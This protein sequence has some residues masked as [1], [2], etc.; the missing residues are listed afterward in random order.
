MAAGALVVACASI[1]YAQEREPSEPAYGATA[2]APRP[3]PSGSALD[4]TASATVIRV[5]ERARALESTDELLHEVPGAQVRR[6]GPI[7]SF[8]GLSLRGANLEH[9]TVL[10]GEIPLGGAEGA[11][12]D[13]S[14]LPLS[15]IDRIEV[16]RGG[17]PLAL[18]FGGIGGVLRLVPRDER[19]TRAEGSVGVG[20][21]G[22]ATARAS[23]TVSGDA[24]TVQTVA[25]M[26][27]ANND[28]PY[29]HDAN[30]HFDPSDDYEARRRNASIDEGW[31]FGRIRA[32]ARGGVLDGIV[33]AY[34]RTG[35]L[36]GSPRNEPIHTRRNLARMLAA[37]RYTREANLE[38]GRHTTFRLST[39]TQYERQRF[40]DLYR[41]VAFTPTA[42]DDRILRT[43]AQA[44]GEIALARFVDLAAIGTLA[45]DRFS[46]DDDLATIDA[47]GSRRRLLGLGGELRAHGALGSIRGEIRASGRVEL[48][49]SKL[50]E[51]RQERLGDT[52]HARTVAPTF[53]LAG[54]IELLRG[55]AFSSSIAT[56]TRIPSLLELFGD[57]AF[58]R[59]ATDLDPERSRTVDVGLVGRA[60][61]GPFRGSSAELRAFTSDVHDLIRY[62]RT[63]QDAIVPE[64]VARATMKGIEI[65][66][67][68][69]LLRRI[70]LTGNATLLRTRDATL[71]RMLP[72]RPQL[73]A[74]A[75]PEWMLG[76]FRGIDAIVLYVDVFHLSSNFTDPYNT[77]VIA[78]RTVFG[79]GAAAE[80]LARRLRVEASVRDLF[81]E[82]PLDLVGFPLPGRS[83]GIEITV[84]TEGGDS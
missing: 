9:T 81:D 7:G 41:E 22:L 47:S 74:Y 69:E 39:A 45:S 27:R 60:S 30:T 49:D 6:L 44:Y 31:A 19:E 79:V 65:G 35:G 46:P 48:A 67:R 21:F 43:F 51:I 8:S 64:N 61:R 42:T 66:V 15:T 62:R 1:A 33:T 26:R 59:G 5:D 83:F 13:L 10:F 58:V 52:T 53:R 55:L 68:G 32:D 70:A 20:S 54:V 82:R 84:R 37:L 34:G 2:V 11:S 18:G 75:R 72:L 36:L 17:A 71:D 14:T 29:R 63:A 25:G 24:V 28:Y 12:F 50:Y 80:L 38:G 23:A 3:I 4:P 56:A 77:S 57:R 73:N 16:Y 40:V 76:P 78:R